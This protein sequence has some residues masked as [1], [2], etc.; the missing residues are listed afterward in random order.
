MDTLEEVKA[1]LAELEKEGGKTAVRM[2]LMDHSAELPEDIR[3]Q[4]IFDYSTDALLEDA[5]DQKLLDD[6]V[7]EGTQALSMLEARKKLVQDELAKL[8]VKERLHMGGS[9]A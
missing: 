7:A 5:A 6:V 4:V 9:A 3:D 2:W 1:K 8:D